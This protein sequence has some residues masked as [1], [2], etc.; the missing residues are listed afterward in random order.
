MP[1]SRNQIKLVKS[2]QQKKFRSANGCFVV[3][4]RKPVLELL[5]SSFEIIHLYATQD[6]IDQIEFTGIEEVPAADM[7]RMSGFSSAPGIL[8]VVRSKEWVIDNMKGFTVILDGIS[9]PGNMGTIIRTA[10]WFGVDRIIATPECVD[11]WSPKVVQSAMG[12]LFR[13]PCSV[14]ESSATR[15][16]LSTENVQVLAA[17]MGG[18]TIS[19]VQRRE[20]QALVIGSESQGLSPFWRSQCDQIVSIQGKGE[21]ESLN[22]AVAASIL[23]YALKGS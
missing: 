7:A 11:F 14:L 3:E 6:H 17:D 21:T 18:I 1:V 16:N 22:A 10:E 8:A 5:D 4:G 2:L 20:N 23:L 19:K 9:D 15:A 13:M 12:S